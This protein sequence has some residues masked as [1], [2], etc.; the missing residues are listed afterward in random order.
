M[1]KRYTFWLWMVIVFQFL[2]GGVHS[3]SFFISQPPRNETERQLTELMETYTIDAGAGFH[4]TMSTLFTALSSCFTLV[5]FLGG[6]INLLLLRNKVS[7]HL[8]KGV[9]R[10]NLVIFGA[11]FVIMLAL[12]FLPPTLFTGLTFLFLIVA[13]LVVPGQEPVEE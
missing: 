10:I 12:T 3:L 5:Y 13:Y 9:L 8:L 6:S 7:L 1:L 2:T 4:P 11:G